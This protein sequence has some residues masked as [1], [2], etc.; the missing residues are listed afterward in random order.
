M[1]CPRHWPRP[2]TPLSAICATERGRSEHTI[3]AYRGDVDALLIHA[4]AEGILNAG[5][6]GPGL[7]APLAGG[8]KR[9]RAGPLHAC[10]PRRHGAQLH[11]LGAAGGNHCRRSGPAAQGPPTGEVAARPCCSSSK[12]AG[13]WRHAAPPQRQGIPWP[14]GTWPWSNFSTA[15]ASVWGS[16]PAWTWTMSTG[17]GAPSRCWARATRNAWFPLGFRPMQALG[18]GSRRRPGS[19]HKPHS[20]TGPVPGPARGPD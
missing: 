9:R 2:P 4:V 20:G 3:R 13:C 18:A 5:R 10:P 17:N 15:R 7:P 6:A 11:R 14:C 19:L 1:P 12:W 8:A 16:W